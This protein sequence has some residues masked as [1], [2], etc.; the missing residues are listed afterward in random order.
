MTPQAAL[1]GVRFFYDISLLLLFGSSLFLGFQAPLSLTRML[2]STLRSPRFVL[3]VICLLTATFAVPVQVAMIGEGWSDALQL[4][5]VRDVMSSTSVGMMFALQACGA[6]ALLCLDFRPSPS[7]WRWTAVV[8]G[9]ML[10]LLAGQGHAMMQQGWIGLAH[11]ANDGLHVLSAGAW[12][13][14]LPPLALV[15][16]RARRTSLSADASIGLRR[17]SI[18]GHAFVAIALLTGI[19]NLLL[20]LGWPETWSTTYRLLLACKIALVLAMVGLALVNRYILVPALHRNPAA[21][22]RALLRGTCG[23]IAL[24]TLVILLV[25]IFGT[26]DP[27]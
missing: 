2:S 18:A 8:S 21:A 19:A 17:F 13:G 27:G 25:A 3:T 9:M 26:L 4:P 5:M 16:L 11:Q 1:V 14:A 15:M 12:F 22:S 23:E 24:G 10:A 20:I 7:S 6:V